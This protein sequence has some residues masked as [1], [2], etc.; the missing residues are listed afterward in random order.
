MNR[1]TSLILLL[2]F[3]LSSRSEI[4]FPASEYAPVEITPA[5][6]TGIDCVYVV[7]DAKD[8]EVTFKSDA[9]KVGLMKYGALGG[10]F[11][12]EA[13]LHSSGK[14]LYRFTLAAEDCGYIISEDGRNTCIW[15]VD[16][17]RHFCSMESLTVAEEESDCDMTRLE[18][19]GDAGKITYYGINGQPETLSRDLR[20]SYSNTEFDNETFST[21]QVTETQTLGFAEKYVTCRTPYCETEFTLSGDRFLKAWGMVAEVTSDIMANPA[22]CAVTRAEQIQ[23]EDNSNQKPSDSGSL[24]GSAPCTVVFSA[25]MSD[26]AVYKEWQISRSPEFDNIDLRYNQEEIE[27]TFTEAGN[28]YVRFE[29]ADASGKCMWQSETYTVSIGESRLE[30]PNAFTPGTSEGVNDEW[31]VSYRSIVEFSCH[32][33]NRWGVKIKELSD[34]SQGWDGKYKGKFVPT[35]VYF[36]VISAKGADG[37]SYNLSGDINVISSKQTNNN[38]SNE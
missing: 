25:L 5:S 20:L 29:C 38:S 32:I 21:S 28:H 18:F 37:K 35:G 2:P 4:I 15:V 24:G 10:G 1:T 34:P 7:Y 19:K 9:A 3:F 11:A 27:Y 13:E 22:V 36:Y 17:S 23:Q 12:Q 31:K 30:C 33:F 14:G 16:Y 26:A 6:S 8:V